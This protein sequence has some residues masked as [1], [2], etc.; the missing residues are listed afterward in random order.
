[1]PYAQILCKPVCSTEGVETR[2]RAHLSLVAT[3]GGTVVSVAG[4]SVVCI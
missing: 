2:G 4:L 3:V 1:M